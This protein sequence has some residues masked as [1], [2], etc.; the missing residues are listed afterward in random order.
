LAV[1]IATFGILLVVGLLPVGMQSTKT[2]LEETSAINIMGAIISDRQATP[3]DQ[4]SKI[5]A[6]PAL[7]N[8]MISP[9]SDV[10][11]VTEGNQ[12]TLALDKARYRVRYTLTP[13]A[14]GTL[15]PFQIWLS[16]S[17]PA[18]SASPSESVEGVS[19]FPQP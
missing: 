17:W 14:S 5:Y 16:V 8:G 3:Y 6:L 1:G 9:V 13:P 18:G 10:F 2:S 4:I 19:T 15:D 12:H 11:G 7:T